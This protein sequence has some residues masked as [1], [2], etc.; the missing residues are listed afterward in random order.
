MGPVVA[1]ERKQERWNGKKDNKNPTFENEARFNNQFDVASQAAHGTIQSLLMILRAAQHNITELVDDTLAWLTVYTFAS[2]LS[3]KAAGIWHQ[4]RETEAGLLGATI[5]ENREKRRN[6][7][8][9]IT[10]GSVP[11]SWDR[12]FLPCTVLLTSESSQMTALLALADCPYVTH[13]CHRTASTLSVS[14]VAPTAHVFRCLSCNF[15]TSA[16]GEG[17][18]CN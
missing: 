11:R 13:L 8:S 1:A 2:T 5:R 10:Q 18:L 14:F 9:A 12:F 16:A 6:Q 15:S 7:R 17:A 3:H 4:S